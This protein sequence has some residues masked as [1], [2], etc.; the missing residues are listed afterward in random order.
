MNHLGGAAAA[1]VHALYQLP[2]G[3]AWVEHSQLV[4]PQELVSMAWGKQLKAREAD[5]VATWKSGG[6]GEAGA[7]GHKRL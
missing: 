7:M 4:G 6:P 5:L 3:T 2:D 1:Q